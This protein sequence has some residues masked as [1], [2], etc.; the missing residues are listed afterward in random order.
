[1]NTRSA[2]ALF[3]QTSLA[4]EAGKGAPDWVQLFPA[5]PD[6]KA[7]DGR[8]WRLSDPQ[9]VVAAFR[10]HGGPLPIDYEHAQAHRA[11]KGEEAPAAGWITGLEVRGGEIWG[12]VDWTSRA[13]AMIEA[14]EYRFL[15]PEFRHTRAGDVT[16]LAGAGLVNRPALPMTALS[17]VNEPASPDASS[18]S[19]ETDMDLTALCRVLGLD[20]GTSLDNILAA[21][22]R[23]QGE[24]RT[25]LA[26]AE[27]PP[28]EHFVPRAD[29][30]QVVARAEEA[31]TSLASLREESRAAEV[32]AEIEAAIVA[33]KVAPASRDHYRSLCAAEGGLE[34]FRNLVGTMPVIGAPSDLDTRDPE[35]RS[36]LTDQQRAVAA[37]LGLSEEEYA[38][39][40]A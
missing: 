13:A 6:L 16:R 7:R 5:G 23:L 39:T 34:A 24:H 28:L 27:T 4:A 25:A 30:D 1:M 26:A 36:A 37:Q 18:H 9:T 38:A 11:P 35:R 19:L 3:S 21:V 22:E 12:R 29:Y 2:T 33:G 14:R 32:D 31:E 15:S 40:G 8:R 20:A 10:E 17:R